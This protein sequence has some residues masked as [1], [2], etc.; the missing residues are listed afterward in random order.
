MR[1]NSQVAALNPFVWDR[2]V[3][4]P[5][6][7]VGMEP[8]AHEVALILKGQTNVAL[9]GARDT[10]KTTFT[11]QLALE[12][13][14]DHGPDAPGFDVVRVDLQR[15]LSLPGFIGCVHDALAGQEGQLVVAEAE[16][17]HSLEHA[18]RPGQDPVA[19]TGRQ[20]AG[21]DLEQAVPV[22]GPVGQRRLE[23]GQLVAVGHQG[24]RGRGQL[25][26]HGDTVGVSGYCARARTSGWTAARPV[27]PTVVGCAR[28]WVRSAS[29]PF[30]W[31]MSGRWSISA[32]P[33]PGS[34]S[35]GTTR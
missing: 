29:R 15:V 14:K 16:L 12:L 28:W 9:F 30:R 1:Y 25:C 24:G 21:E 22:R 7:I 31:R 34:R 10:G 5:S 35:S 23:H 20:P 4:D 27:L 17:G 19:A 8:F 2:P 26:A 32:R 3:D 13:A 11:T 33:T 18:P 6:K